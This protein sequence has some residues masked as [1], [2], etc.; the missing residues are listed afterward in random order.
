MPSPRCCSVTGCPHLKLA[1]GRRHQANPTIAVAARILATESS[2]SMGHTGH[3]T[4]QNGLR[5]SI[6]GPTQR[7]RAERK[8]RDI[9]RE[10]HSQTRVER[11]ERQHKRTSSHPPISSV[12]SVRISIDSSGQRICSTCS[13][14]ISS[15]FGVANSDT[16][17]L[18]NTLPR[19]RPSQ[20]I[21]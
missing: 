16:G 11:S 7:T 8:N 13:S 4:P 21:T 18:E 6:S 15:N 19:G 12:R 17:T 9:E 3:G 14:A 1:Q 20:L 2:I 10:S 5:R